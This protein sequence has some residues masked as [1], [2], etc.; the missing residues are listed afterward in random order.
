M[1]DLKINGQTVGGQIYKLAIPDGKSLA[2]IHKLGQN[3]G[4]DQVYF[5][6]KDQMYFVEGVEL[7][8]DGLN[9]R[10]I[11]KID[12]NIDG[13]NHS[14][15]VLLIDNE[16][17]SAWEGVTTVIN[18][19][20]DMVPD[21]PE[22]NLADVVGARRLNEP[23]VLQSREDAIKRRKGKVPLQ[24]KFVGPDKLPIA[25]SETFWKLPT[26]K[27]DIRDLAAT[28]GDYTARKGLSLAQAQVPF[29]PTDGSNL[30]LQLSDG[31]W[32]LVKVGFYSSG[33][34]IALLGGAIYG[35]TK[36]Q[37]DEPM[38]PFRTQP[39]QDSGSQ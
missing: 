19:V 18:N 12:L 35:S 22:E 31:G 11:P 32:D 4:Y 2:D 16:V 23:N 6:V 9:E 36:G 20:V 7:E 33:T 39:L 27:T 8:L 21:S 10:A 1:P 15:E 29:K 37:D 17:D 13:E 3:D 24:A 25:F 26:E 28:I 14:A 5:Q 34:I 30:G 38:S